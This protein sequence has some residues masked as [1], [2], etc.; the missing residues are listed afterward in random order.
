LETSKKLNIEIHPDTY[1]FMAQC[2]YALNKIPE[3]LPLFEQAIKAEKDA[4]YNQFID[5]HEYS[6]AEVYANLNRF[7][8][9]LSLE[10]DAIEFERKAPL[11]P[12]MERDCIKELPLAVFCENHEQFKQ[13][14]PYR[15]AVLD[16]FE[17]NRGLLDPSTVEQR[18]ELAVDLVKSGR[19]HDA[20]KLYKQL[21]QKV[22]SSPQSEP[23]DLENAEGHFALFCYENGKE[24]LAERLWKQELRGLSGKSSEYDLVR[25]NVIYRNLAKLAEMQHRKKQVKNYLL[26]F[27]DISDKER[28]KFAEGIHL[29]NLRKLYKYYADAGEFKSAFE[30]EDEILSHEREAHGV[31]CDCRPALLTELAFCHLRARDR[32]VALNLMTAALLERKAGVTHT[33]SKACASR[34]LKPIEVSAFDEFRPF[35]VELP[36]EFYLKAGD[37]DKALRIIREEPFERDELNAATRLIKCARLFKEAKNFD[38]AEELLDRALIHKSFHDKVRN[39]ADLALLYLE[40]KQTNKACAIYESLLQINNDIDASNQKDP[41]PGFSPIC[42]FPDRFTGSQGW[43]GPDNYRTAGGKECLEAWTGSRQLRRYQEPTPIF[44]WLDHEPFCCTSLQ[45]KA[46][47]KAKLAEIYYREKCDYMKS[48]SLLDEAMQILEA[49]THLKDVYLKA[50]NLR[51]QIVSE[52]GI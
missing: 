22:S 16:Y 26:A 29:S 50:S 35:N 37:A 52:M 5:S 30:L 41:L 45:L 3:S 1:I 46:V 9:A 40:T 18:H 24:A 21:I 11:P 31:S 34:G 4:G 36:V 12:E 49:S 48:I 47:V 32:E 7:N 20:L 39:R 10:R 19:L 27:G 33:T 23:G 28:S 15:Q 14:V 17:Q 43:N 25:I 51:S 2:K 6:L 44:S 13:A 42:L 8:E 38:E